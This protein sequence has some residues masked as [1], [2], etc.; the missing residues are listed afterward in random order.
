MI[1]QLSRQEKMLYAV[2]VLALISHFVAT[3]RQ[4]YVKPLTARKVESSVATPMPQRS[5]AEQQTSSEAFSNL[6]GVK[7][8]TPQQDEQQPKAPETLIDM[9]PKLLAIDAVDG[10]LTARLWLN[11][12]Q[13]SK[14]LSASVGDAMHSYTLS[15]L[16]SS[17]AEFTHNAQPDEQPLPAI[18]LQLFKARSE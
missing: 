8:Q 17:T 16:S 2:V 15:A 12:M 14:L 6:F 10:K 9:Q 13:G 7:P 4:T 18:K 1:N 3:L 5:V 11:N